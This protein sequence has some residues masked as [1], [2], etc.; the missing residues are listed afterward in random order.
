MCAAVIRA[1]LYNRR[2]HVLK[3]YAAKFKIF[4]QNL[5]LDEQEAKS[6]SQAK[7]SWWTRGQS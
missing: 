1:L 7:V 3:F 2:Y 6:R 4:I 5:S